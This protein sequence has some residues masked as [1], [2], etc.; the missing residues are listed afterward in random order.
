MIEMQDILYNVFAKKCT[1]MFKI[2]KG[3]RR[4]FWAEVYWKVY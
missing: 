4:S 1:D 2:N 3:L